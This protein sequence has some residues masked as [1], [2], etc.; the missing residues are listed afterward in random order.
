[1][2]PTYTNIYNRVYTSL[3]N[4]TE[5]VPH[6]ELHFAAQGITTSLWTMYTY[7]E[8]EKLPKVADTITDVILELFQ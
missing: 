4:S 1:M 2:I 7:V 3:E 8:R 6:E 5:G